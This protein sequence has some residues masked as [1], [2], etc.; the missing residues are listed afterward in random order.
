MKRPG[1]PSNVVAVAIVALGLTGSATSHAD[2]LAS[3]LDAHLGGQTLRDAGKLRAARQQ[4]V[5]CA[6]DACPAPVRKDCSQWLQ[7]TTE[8]TPTLL[9]EARGPTGD[10]MADVTVSVDGEPLLPRLTGMPVPVDPGEHTLRFVAADGR[11]REQR[12][13][14]TVGDKNRHVTVQFADAAAPASAPGA[15]RAPSLASDRATPVPPGVFVLGG[16]GLVGISAFAFFGIEALSRGNHLKST[17]APTC[18]PDDASAVHRDAVIADVSLAVSVVALGA[19]AWLFATR[20]SSTPSP[21]TSLLVAPT[22]AGGTV[23]WR[24]TF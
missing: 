2:G 3:C 18:S 11:T 13:M 14:L 20:R 15:S 24:A 7:E 8:Q 21:A 12:L 1:R 4:F 23:A 10:G 16:V 22:A 5:A 19:A 6:A 9:I 17:C